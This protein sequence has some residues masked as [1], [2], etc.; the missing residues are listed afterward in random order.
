MTRRVLVV[1]F[2]LLLKHAFGDLSI[3]GMLQHA[4]LPLDAGTVSQ[5]YSTCFYGLQLTRCKASYAD[6][7][8]VAANDLLYYQNFD[9]VYGTPYCLQCCGIDRSKDIWDLSCELNDVTV[10]SSN[11]YGY[12]FRFARNEYPED[13]RMVRCPLK[14]SACTYD[15]DGELIA[16]ESAGDIQKLKGY[17]ITMHVVTYNGNFDYWRGVTKCEVETI[18]TNETLNSGDLFYEKF[19]IHHDIGP[20]T[21]DAFQI[22]FLWLLSVIFIYIVLY[23]CRRTH[24]LVCGKKLVIFTDLCY[25]CRFYG[26]EPPDPLLVKAL[27]EKAAHLQGTPPQR[28]WC[29]KRIVSC[30][31]ATFGCCTSDFDNV[32]P[33]IEEET[34]E[35]LSTYMIEEQPVSALPKPKPVPKMLQTK[36]V[37]KVHPYVLYKSTGIENPPVPEPP[38]ITID[39]VIAKKQSQKNGKK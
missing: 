26:A 14:R 36:H 27:R 19:I 8:V 2:F 7:D 18:E 24:C 20:H 29:S 34:K 33:V 30:C 37:I 28:F 5:V 1:C 12:E 11:L 4:E 15:D 23:Y 17:I 31:R 9:S 32:K 16:C 13:V 39:Q 6:D 10:I 25:L 21:Y 22:V 3:L 38:P 35:D